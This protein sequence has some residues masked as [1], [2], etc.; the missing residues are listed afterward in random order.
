[1]EYIRQSINNFV[2]THDGQKVFLIIYIGGAAVIAL[3]CGL[4]YFAIWVAAHFM[5]E[6]YKYYRI[7][8]KLYLRDIL[9]SLYHCKLDIMFLMV[10]LCIDVVSHQSLLLATA[11]QEVRIL[12]F[13]RFSRIA[14]LGRIA[15]IARIMPRLFGTVKASMCVFHLSNELSGHV[16]QRH[17]SKIN[18][19]L[20][21]LVIVTI[22]VVS[23]IM[24]FMIPLSMGIGIHEILHSIIEVLSP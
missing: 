10:G 8:S 16:E 3:L 7:S 20:Q 14:S 2:V 15:K 17:E 11:N 12:S 18:W 1:M 5:L 21:D 24:I 22:I 13:L 19:K 9:L 23:I 6:L 4:F